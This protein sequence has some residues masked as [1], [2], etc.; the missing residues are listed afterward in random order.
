M[1]KCPYCF[2]EI[3]KHAVY[4]NHV[5]WCKHNPD[6]ARIK[7]QA[8]EKLSRSADQKRLVS[9]GELKEFDVI[10]VKCLIEFKVTEHEYEFPKKLNY[11]CSIFCANS[12][13]VTQEH[14]QKTA[15]AIKQYHIVKG[16]YSK[17]AD[18]QC[19]KEY[20]GKICYSCKELRKIKREN[21]R[22][23]KRAQRSI[24]ENYRLDCDFKFSLSNYPDKFD[25]S[26]IKQY[27][28]YNPSN[29]KKPNLNGISRDHMVSVRFGFDNG[30]PAD[31]ISHPANCQLLRHCDNQHKS[32]QCS[33]SIDEL[34]RRIDEWTKI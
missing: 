20:R 29:S 8:S 33:I 22:V 34:Y 23:L 4:A 13:D 26:L 27:G 21:D 10:C 3:E 14:K 7:A 12:K 25:A 18:C 24:F 6:Y 30:I 28:W 15:K 32:S 31:I 17:C 11:F 9:K 16:T 2:V 5:R 1:K 19:E